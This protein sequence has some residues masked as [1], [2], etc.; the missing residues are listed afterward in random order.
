MPIFISYSEKDKAFADKLAMNLVKKK[1]HVWMDR[2]E[3]NVGDSLIDKI[4]SALTDSSAILILL[5][6][7]SVDSAWCKKEINSGLVRE[8]AERQTLLIP[9]LIEDCEIPLF[10]RDKLYADFRSRPDAALRQIDEALSRISN[11]T[12]GRIE[13]PKFHTDWAND[14]KRIDGTWL[15][16]WV[17][18]DH[19]HE[20]PYVTLSRCTVLCDE[21]ASQ[22][23]Q[24]LGEDDRAKFRRDALALL[25]SSIDG[26]GLTVLIEDAFEKTMY[27]SLESE[28]GNKFRV[29]ISYR[30][31]GIDNGKDTVLYL[32]N[33]LRMALKHMT[34]VMAAPKKR[35][36][37]RKRSGKKKLIN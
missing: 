32:D 11:P 26:N 8:L 20:W 12:Q 16:D 34:D 14:W 30:R 28:S 10:L 21:A 23:F 25:V 35:A 33:N 15:F 6:K 1:H 37:E 13:S 9:C 24:E 7:N 4:Q 29:A 19:G 22:E 17:F 3:L 5:S 27:R 31:M 18:V 36:S 2:W